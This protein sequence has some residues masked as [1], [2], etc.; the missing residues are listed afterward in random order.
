VK[1][2]FVTFY[3]PGSFFSEETTKEVKSWDTNV[4]I[5]MAIKIKERHGAIPYGFRFSTR[6][7]GPK[8]LDSKETKTSCFYYLGGKVETLKEIESRNDPNEKILLSNMK[9]N[10][11]KKVIVNTNSWKFTAG[12]NKDDVVLEFIK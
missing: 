12:L 2:N 5:E 9:N 8:D 10:G 7:R 3:S 1:Q 4:A 6:E 11:F